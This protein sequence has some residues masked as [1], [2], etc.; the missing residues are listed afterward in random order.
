MNIKKANIGELKTHL[1][2]YVKSVKGGGKVL[3]TERN[4]PVAKIVPLD[5][6]DMYESEEEQLIAEGILSLSRPKSNKPLPDSFWDS[7]DLPKVPLDVILR[8]IREERDED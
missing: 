1:S 5:E 2:L 7:K 8:V 4:K 6:D 3:I